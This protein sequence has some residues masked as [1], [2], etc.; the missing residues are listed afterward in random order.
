[1]PESQHSAGLVIN[2]G[3][4]HRDGEG[5][6]ISQQASVEPPRIECP[7]ISCLWRYTIKSFQYTLLML[8]HKYRLQ[9]AEANRRKDIPE[10]YRTGENAPESMFGLAKEIIKLRIKL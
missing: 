8:Y 4:E 5:K 10:Y 3:M 7:K 1:M 2:W 9:Y 6:L